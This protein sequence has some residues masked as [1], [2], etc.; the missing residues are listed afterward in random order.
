[1]VPPVARIT[2]LGLAA[3]ADAAAVTVNAMNNKTLMALI[4]APYR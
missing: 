4:F 1:M 3:K 2:T